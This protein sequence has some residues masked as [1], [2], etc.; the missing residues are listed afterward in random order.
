MPRAEYGHAFPIPGPPEYIAMLVGT[1]LGRASL[2]H[3]E[4]YRQLVLQKKATLWFIPNSG[5]CLF[6]IR[7]FGSIKV[8][9][10]VFYAAEGFNF[11]KWSRM[12]M[13][14]ALCEQEK[15]EGIFVHT[16][17]RRIQKWLIRWGFMELNNYGDFRWCHGRQRTIDFGKSPAEI[18]RELVLGEM[19]ASLEKAFGAD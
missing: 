14:F 12:K 13:L 2:G 17:N 3:D 8:K 10:L 1:V 19:N 18:T 9:E 4:L 16:T 15:C 5:F 6:G 7:Y 11:V